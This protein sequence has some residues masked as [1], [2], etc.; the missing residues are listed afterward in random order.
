MIRQATVGH[1]VR[2]NALEIHA[3]RY[4]VRHCRWYSLRAARLA[5]PMDPSIPD[6]GSPLD[7]G[8]LV[9]GT[10]H[11]RIAPKFDSFFAEHMGRPTS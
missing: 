4:R 10:Y 6:Q 11:P 2:M 8:A 9:A 1:I 5:W 3:I 7:I